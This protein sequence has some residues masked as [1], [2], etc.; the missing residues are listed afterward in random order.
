MK[1]PDKD[2]WEAAWRGLDE[3]CAF[4]NFYEKSLKE[5]LALFQQCAVVY[6]ED[7]VYMP[8]SPFRYYVRAYIYYLASERSRSDSDAANCFLM[9]IE[10]RFRDHPDWLDCS[11]SRIV[12]V[13][14]KIAEQQEDF[15][16]ANQTI[17]GD[18]GKRVRRL[19]DNQ[20]KAEQA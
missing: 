6:Q 8:E 7:L 20:T 15:Y 9:L 10:T 2:D 1:I 3:G 17:Y 16:D 19:L 11:W 4:R 5:A 13:L 14:Q 12:P 18:F